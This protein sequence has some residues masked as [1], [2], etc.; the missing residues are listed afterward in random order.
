M[1]RMSFR[2]TL[3]DKVPV[4]I[5]TMF[6]GTVNLIIRGTRRLYFLLF[7]CRAHAQGDATN[8]VKELL[9]KLTSRFQLQLTLSLV[10]S[11]DR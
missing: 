7:L 1:D 10:Q 6:T 2:P 5:H 4:T 8:K 9:S 3:P 11:I